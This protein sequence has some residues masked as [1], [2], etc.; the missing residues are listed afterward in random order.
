MSSSALLP[1]NISL[2]I[3]APT[4]LSTLRPVTSLDIYDRP[5]GNFHD[6]GLFSVLTFGRVGD[7]LRDKKFGYIPLRLPILHPTLYQRLVRL[8]SLYGEI[9]SGTGFGKW[10]P[11]LKDFE[12]A[13]ALTGETGYTFFM[14]HWDEFQPA[15]TGSATRDQR[16]KTILTYKDQAFL[17]HMLV[18]PA[19]L[20]EAEVGS[21]GRTT[22]DEVNELYQK[23]LIQT[24]NLP[25]SS[26]KNDDLTPYDR[27]RYGI[28]LTLVAIV[29]YF[30]KMISGKKGF[31]QGRFA[32][33]RV[34]DGTRGV[35]SSS[36]T[37]SVDL[38]QP[39]HPG[40]ND[41]VLGMYQTAKAVQPKAV[42][43]L[44][45]SILGEVFDTASDQVELINPDTYRKEWVTVTPDI[46]DHYTT[47][48][49]LER[50]IDEISVPEKRHRPV[51]VEGYYIGLVYADDQANFRVFRDIDELPDTFDSR[52][53]RP[54]T[55]L[56]LIYLAGYRHWNKNAA[57][58]TRYP[59]EN[60]LSSYPSK[61]YVKTTS[62][63]DLR[64]ELG[65]DWTR[66]GDD[67][68]ALEYP[69]FDGEA[70]TYHDSVSISPSRLAPLGGDFDGDQVSVVGVYT[71]DGI[72]EIDRYLTKRAAYLRAGGGLAFSANIHTVQL[73]ARAMSGPAAA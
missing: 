3:P 61:I 33:R 15:Y 11:D 31:S 7:E 65:P 55:Y 46:V 64:Y 48:E 60:F 34:F 45:T 66:L 53:V 57:F 70:T 22:M 27:S 49:G 5:G 67:Y 16:V 50:F 68:R 6:D 13:D 32:S 51:T 44:K 21:D 41:T 18:L 14:S 2:L 23:L 69:R 54:L 40:F 28:Q 20:R 58:V 9:L 26:P 4:D 1:F 71:Q 73:T 62:V 19:G 47:P 8:K 24:R 42:Y 43:Y 17:S 37:A 39:N 72:A 10:N 35:I 56:E 36:D 12:R 30:E 59:V 38:G 63:G 25:E 29:E 52:F